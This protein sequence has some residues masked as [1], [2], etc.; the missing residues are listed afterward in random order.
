MAKPKTIYICS[1]CAAEFSQWFGKCS[2]C[3]TYDSLVEQN[4]SSFLGDIPGRGGVGNWQAGGHSKSHG[5]PAKAR[6]SL[7]FDQ[8]SDRQI[9]RWESGYGELDRVL[10]GGVVPGSMVLIGGDP[11]IGKST[12]LLQV[13]NQ[14]AQKYRILYVTGEESG[15]QVKLR[16]SRLGMSKPPL[17]VKEDHQNKD[18]EAP[19]TNP[20]QPIDPDSIG[21]DLYIL[22][23]TDLE[24][25]LREIDS[26]KPNVAVIDSIQ[27]VFLPALTSAPGSV[28]Q[29]RECTA[30]L[31]KVAKHEDITMLIVGHVTK[32]GTIAGPRVL[33]HL[34][35]TVLYFEGDRFASH[36]LLRTVKN[37]FGATHEIG[38]FEMV[39]QGLREVD[40]P[41]ELFLGNRDDPAPGTAIVVACE[42]TRPIV[43]ELQALVSPT[44]YPSPRRAGTGI[45]YNRLVQILAVLEKRVGIPMSKLDSYVASAGGLNVEE[46]AVDLGIAVAIVASFRDRIV[47]P[48][49]VLIGEV[50]LGGQVR[51]VSQMEL[52]LKEAAKLGF[53]RAI[54]PKGTKF[55]EIGIEILPVGKVIDAIIAAVPHQELTE[56]DLEPDG[57]E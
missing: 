17:I 16:A 55:P 26:L 38:I 24:E 34:V 49:T 39:S 7:T 42:G 3:D 53:K 15:Q 48:G 46:P 30:A 27:T 57:D 20:Q 11:G 43:V 37:R 47:D 51:S 1:N 50:G 41:S 22:P 4:I 8:I 40:N 35:D 13:S 44:S 5:K 10:G 29:V 52:R 54:V 21:A 12:L 32:E 56:E 25:I 33:E 2:N 19:V 14:L 36:R 23:E 28:A 31:M 6:S 18:P 9:A 45:D